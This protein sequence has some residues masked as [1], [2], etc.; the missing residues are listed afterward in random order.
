M[1]AS[2]TCWCFS[3]FVWFVKVLHFSLDLSLDG[4]DTSPLWHPFMY[5]E[6]QH[7]LKGIKL[8]RRR[9]VLCHRINSLGCFGF[10]LLVRPC[11]Y[12]E[13]FMRHIHLSPSL[14]WKPNFLWNNVVGV[15]AFQWLV[16][17]FCLPL[18][19]GV[20]VC[21]AVHH[22]KA[23]RGKK[24]NTA[25]CRCGARAHLFSWF[26]GLSWTSPGVSAARMQEGKNDKK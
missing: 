14:F 26:C 12:P 17:T 10:F 23:G 13:V 22:G 15:S 20:F 16:A 5:P 8:L 9:L 24:M 11:F 4:S 19:S 21:F 3:L 6:I 18:H 2:E 7:F 25:M 1:A